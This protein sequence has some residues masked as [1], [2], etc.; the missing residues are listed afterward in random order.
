MCS[1]PCGAWVS[2]ICWHIVGVQ[3]DVRNEQRMLAGAFKFAL[4]PKAG[5]MQITSPQVPA[6]TLA[7]MLWLFARS[8]APDAQQEAGAADLMSRE[9]SQMCCS[10]FCR[11][12]AAEPP[13]VQ[14]GR[15]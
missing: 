8:A 4:E 12:N 10:W 3:R 14:E 11:L 7:S 13:R 1:L 9:G 15:S 2:D 6:Q 5:G